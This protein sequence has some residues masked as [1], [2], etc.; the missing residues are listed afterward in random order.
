MLQVHSSH[1]LDQ[2]EL[3]LRLAAERRGGSILA[4]SHVGQL[5]QREQAPGEV[6][7]IAVTVCF[8]DLYTALLNADIRF[9]AFLPSR[10]AVCTKGEGT[11]LETVAPREYCRALH[12]T[13]LETL[14]TALE[15]ALRAVMEEAAQPHSR[16]LQPGGAAGEHRATEDQVNMRAALPQRIDCHGSKVEEMAGTGSH[17]AQ[18]G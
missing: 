3:T 13:D 14:A 6:D 2:I 1:R 5:L 9:A 8:S 11:F 10:I 12:R 4:I 16:S 15:D 7:A 18:G 17:D